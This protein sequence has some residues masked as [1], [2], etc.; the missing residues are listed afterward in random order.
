MFNYIID[1][2][3][4]LILVVALFS[5][6]FFILAI[7][8]FVSNRRSTNDLYR[9]I[10]EFRNSLNNT[11]LNLNNSIN[12]EFNSF[13]DRLNSNLIQANRNNNEVF[14]SINEKMIKINETQKSLNQLSQDIINLQSILTD[15]KTRGIF[16]ETEL[17]SLLEM[18]YGN[19]YTFYQKQYHLNNGSV[20]DAVIFGGE[21]MG[22]LCID[23]KFPLENYRR[24][25]DDKLDNV[26]KQLASKMFVQDVKKHINDIAD[27]Y[28][29][30]GQTCKVAYMFIPAEAIF[31]E[32]Y[33][34][35]EEVVEYSYQKKVYLVS[36]TTLMAYIT[37]IKSIYLGQKKDKKAKQIE[38]LLAELAVE[39]TRFNERNE[40]LYK[41]YEKLSSDF[42][43]L[44]TTANKISKKFNKLNQGDI[45]E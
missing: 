2:N 9:N 3:S 30:D 14:N 24:I 31:S 35:Y 15:K 32:I 4:F 27:K 44:S 23:S 40:I 21:S 19:D 42:I 5:L 17:Y 34:S 8:I 11:F 12:D 13:S 45:D 20:A 1:N 26:S 18:A 29:I 33:A 37:A 38:I 7:V 39:F 6:C 28:I 16:G 22:V 41:D 36:P 10:N 43:A 25:H